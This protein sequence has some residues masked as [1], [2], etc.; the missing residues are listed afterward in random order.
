MKQLAEIWGP[1]AEYSGEIL[2]QPVIANLKEGLSVLHY[3]IWIRQ[4]L[5]NPKSGGH[6][7]WASGI[8]TLAHRA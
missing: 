1:L 8:S 5:V 7:L 2:E 4:T 3:C 6:S